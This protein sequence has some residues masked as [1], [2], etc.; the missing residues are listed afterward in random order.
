FK[1]NSEANN[2]YRFGKEGII[3]EDNTTV[4]MV[5]A[6]NEELVIAQDTFTLTK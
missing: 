1:V 3:S 4:A 2:T 5:I 6:T